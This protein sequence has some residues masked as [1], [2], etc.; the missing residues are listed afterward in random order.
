MGIRCDYDEWVEHPNE[1][2]ELFWDRVVHKQ[3][4]KG[5]ELTIEQGSTYVWVGVPKRN[6]AFFQLKS[7]KRALQNTPEPTPESTRL[8]EKCINWALRI[9][10]FLNKFRLR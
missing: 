3:V 8:E 4:P 9:A 7:T 1:S 10:A 2:A 5:S 6:I